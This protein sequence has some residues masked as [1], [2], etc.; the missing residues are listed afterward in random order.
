MSGGIEE[1]SAS[2]EARSAPRSYPTEGRGWQHPRLLGMQRRAV[3]KGCPQV[4]GSE[5]Q[6]LSGCLDHVAMRAA[7]DPQDDRQASHAL[8]PNQ[9]DLDPALRGVGQD[10]NDA[11]FG[12]VDVLDRL[13]RLDQPLPEFEGNGLKI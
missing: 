4:L 5:A 2:F 7:V 3:L 11:V 13:S 9:S 10:R 8:R 1:T 12:K 6:S